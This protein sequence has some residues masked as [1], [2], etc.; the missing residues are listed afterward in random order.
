MQE[1]LLASAIESVQEKRFA[2]ILGSE[3]K[4]ASNPN[5]IFVNKPKSAKKWVEING[6]EP[7]STCLVPD[8][9]H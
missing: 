9:P 5:P 1:Q 8:P 4:I 6:E 2:L 3:I 7:S